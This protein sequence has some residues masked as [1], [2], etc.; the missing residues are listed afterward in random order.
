MKRIIYVTEYSF[1]IVSIAFLSTFFIDDLIPSIKAKAIVL[2]T[3]AV[4]LCVYKT[5][6][7]FRQIKRK[8]KIEEIHFLG[9][10]GVA[11]TLILGFIIISLS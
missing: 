9:L 7:W 5:F 11:T 8:E 1:F 10:T 6:M 4:M 3:I 2:L